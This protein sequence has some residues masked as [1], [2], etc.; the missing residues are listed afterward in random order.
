MIG[1]IIGD[2]VGSRFEF[3]NHRSTQFNLFTNESKFTDDTFCTI[4]VADWI[5]NVNMWEP[6]ERGNFAHLM[7]GWCRRFPDGNYGLGFRKWINNPVPYNSYGN[8]AAMRISSIGYFFAPS[9][10]LIYASDFVTS[11]SHDHPEGLKG[12]RV[13][14]EAGSMAWRGATK[15]QI[16]A[17]ISELGYDLNITCD[18]IRASNLFDET[19]QVTVPQALVCFLESTDFESSIRLAVSIGGDSDTIAAIAGGLAEAFY[20]EIPESMIAEAQMRLPHEMLAVV[21]KF[22][23]KKPK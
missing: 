16:R 2:I 20:K 14:A 19:C 9:S 7:Q 17:F 18:S 21:D 1:A 12:A 15:A 23:L 10:K 3:N 13:I 22:Y 11:V 4:A 8:G 6:S 5:L